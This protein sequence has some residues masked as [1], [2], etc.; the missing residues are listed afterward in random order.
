MFVGLVYNEKFNLQVIWSYEIF[1]SRKLTN[2]LEIIKLI[3]I[4]PRNWKIE[5]WYKGLWKKF[6]ENAGGY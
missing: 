6:K 4:K 1:K 3:W 2:Y 5:K